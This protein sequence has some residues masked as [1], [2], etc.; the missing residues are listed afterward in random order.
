MRVLVCGGRDYNNRQ[1]VFA[2]MDAI[3]VQRGITMVIHGACCESNAPTLLRGA[4]RWA[5][6]WASENEIPCLRVP[7]KWRLDGKRAGP[8]RNGEMLRCKPALVVAFPGG[9]GTADMVGRAKAAGIAVFEVPA[10]KASE[11]TP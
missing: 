9:R 6:E 7:A 2:A 10:D 1:R 4:D 5:D 3:H 11:G 8:V